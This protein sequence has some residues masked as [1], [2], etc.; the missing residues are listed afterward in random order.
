MST[1]LKSTARNGDSGA[2]T[3]QRKPAR[4]S[5]RHDAPQAAGLPRWLQRRLSVN[6]AGDAYEQE[7]DRVAEQAMQQPVAADVS[8]APLG[9]QRLGAPSSG[10]L[11]AAP[12]SVADALASPGRPLEPM[13]RHDMEQRFGQ[14][15]SQVRVHSDAAADQ[16]AQD[17]QARAY[18]VGNQIVFAK[19]EYA[20][21]TP[22]GRRLLAHELAHTVQQSGGAPTLVARQPNQP[23]AAGQEDLVNLRTTMLSFYNLLTPDER[24]SLNRN[25]TVVIALVS[26][27]N[28][29]TLVYTV[30]SNSTNPGM[31]AAADQL[32]LT[33]WDPEGI[34]KVAGERHAE[35]LM[36]E[37]ARRQGFKM[38]GIAVTREPC[39]DCGPLVSQKGIPIEW[40]RDPNPVPARGKPP[41]G[42]NPPAGGSQAGQGAARTSASS[43]EED[44][45]ELLRG[46]SR[47]DIQAQITALVVDAGLQGF[48]L[49]VLHNIAAKSEAK[50]KA[51]QQQIRDEIAQRIAAQGSR[52]VDLWIDEFL[53]IYA[54]VTIATTVEA[55]TTMPGGL[56]PSG[57]GISFTGPPETFV[58]YIEGKL[59]DVEISPTLKV[60]KRSTVVPGPTDVRTTRTVETETSGIFLPVDSDMVRTRLEERIDEIDQEMT[61]SPSALDNF[62]LQ[63]MRDDLK[64]KLALFGS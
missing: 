35:Q 16:S 1:A 7:A 18:A 14:D 8:P 63:L 39:A 26:H 29:P 20:P 42:G 12:A 64:R 32:G 44:E 30:A 25:T 38:H 21:H 3:T 45:P 49:W 10:Q 60:E 19:G 50:L 54:N 52:I 24:A 15:F 56:T 11:D 5:G 2:K 34:D 4:E 61:R 37:S 51:D 57:G 17:V 59:I 62:S 55:T 28:Q 22:D 41:A 47:I 36:V 31:R 6:Q 58:R 27:D 40:V 23:F 43:S 46:R 33:R 48:K 9:I 13:P 53:P